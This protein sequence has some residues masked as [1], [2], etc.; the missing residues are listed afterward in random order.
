MFLKTMNLR[1]VVAHLFVI[2]I[3]VIAAAQS[4]TSC[5]SV[6]ICYWVNKLNLNTLYAGVDNRIAIKAQGVKPENIFVELSGVGGRPLS[7]EALG[8]KGNNG[9][10]IARDNFRW[11]SF[12]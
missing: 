6:T 7:A 12:T 8:I 2:P 5:D 1:L 3:S 10:Y 9:F 11:R 4:E